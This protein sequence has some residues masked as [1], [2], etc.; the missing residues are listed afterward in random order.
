M[1]YFFTLTGFLSITCRLLVQK[2]NCIL[3]RKIVI[4]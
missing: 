4:L 2:T 1:F 3:A